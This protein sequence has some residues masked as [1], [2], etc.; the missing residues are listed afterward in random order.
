MRTH[1][2]LLITLC[3]SQLF[4]QNEAPKSVSLTETVSSTLLVPRTKDYNQA[5]S[6]M[7]LLRTKIRQQ[8]QAKTIDSTEAGILFTDGLLEEIIPHWYGT[9]WDFNG[10]SDVPQQGK[11][12]C[13]YFVSTT[14]LHAGIRLD[15]YKLAQQ[16]PLDEA[17]ALNMQQ[18]V[19]TFADV[20]PTQMAQTI[21]DTFK[22]GL[23]F[24]GLDASH[25]G[26]LLNRA[27]KLYFIHANYT[28]S[29]VVTIQP[30]MESV[31]SSFTTWHFA[32]ITHNRALLRHWLNGKPCTLYYTK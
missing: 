25:V 29:A 11:I 1:F 18:P 10:Y 31:F 12:A 8:L 26:Y 15:R 23:Y 2:I 5:K 20:S 22:E 27:G 19:G 14:L 21:T 24:I 17:I 3:V 28:G 4:C 30:L 16:S 9:V 32:Y 6:K 13:G 7:L